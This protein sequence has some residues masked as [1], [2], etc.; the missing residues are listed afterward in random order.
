MKVWSGRKGTAPFFLNLSTRCRWLVN[1]MSQLL[2]PNC[3]EKPWCPL[4][5]RL[6]GCQR[7]AGWFGRGAYLLSLLGFERRTAQPIVSVLLWLLS[8]NNRDPECCL[9]LKEWNPVWKEPATTCVVYVLGFCVCHG[10]CGGLFM[11]LREGMYGGLEV[12]LAHC[13]L[14][15][16]GEQSASCPV[17]FTPGRRSLQYPLIRVLIGPQSQSACS[18]G[19]FFVPTWIWDLIPWSPIP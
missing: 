1:F 18:G 3:P 7:W 15:H 14:P 4:N 9:L 19:N 10:V 11:S 12:Y 16:G 6:G 5:R 2:P 17:R 8:Y 13:L